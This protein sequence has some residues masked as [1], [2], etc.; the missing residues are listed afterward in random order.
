MTATRLVLEHQ[1]HSTNGNTAPTHFNMPL[2]YAYMYLFRFNAY[3]DII[4]TA[5]RIVTEERSSGRPSQLQTTGVATLTCITQ[6][7]R[8]EA[9]K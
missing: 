2:C 5:N 6:R 1:R 4:P 9:L 7:R 3:P 8:N